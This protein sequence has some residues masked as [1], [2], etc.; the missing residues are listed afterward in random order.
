MSP[1]HS[2]VFA[3]SSTHADK[4]AVLA[5]TPDLQEPQIAAAR[6]QAW[7]QAG[8]ALLTLEAARTWLENYGLV[9]F[10]P[11]ALG[12]P[13]PSLVEATL[14]TEKAAVAPAEADT[15][16]TLV[17]RMVAEGSALPLNL[18]GTPGDLPDFVVSAAAFPFVFTLR[19]DK[20]W[21]RPPE[22]SG[23]VKVTPLALR[24][25]ELLAE[26]GAMTVAD[27]VSEAGREVT[28]SAISRS[29]NEL[30][31][32]LRVI[33]VLQQ[34][35]GETLWELTTA[36]FSKAVKAG[37]N[38]GQ[39]TA[40]SALIS[41]YL[42][43]VYIGS[44][45][46]IAT[47]LSPLTARSRVREVLHGLV[48]GRQLNEAVLEGKAVLYVPDTLPE[49][50]VAGE[51]EFTD[52]EAAAE[53]EED[54]DEGNEDNEDNEGHEENE[55]DVATEPGTEIAPGE[56]R[57]GRFQ[58]APESRSA[59]NGLR[60]K[61]VRREGG[62]RPPAR[63]GA[64]PPF[65]P[66][67]RPSFGGDR[68]GAS[69]AARPRSAG[70][71]ARSA[72]PGTRGGGYGARGAGA[73][74]TF[75]RGAGPSDR[76]PGGPPRSFGP[77]PPRGDRPGAGAGER[78]AFNRPWDEERASRPPRS[79]G[80]A[81]R[82]PRPP[83]RGGDD[84]RPPRREGSSFP[85]PARPPFR[86]GEDSR[87]PRRDAGAPGAD[88]PYARPRPSSGPREG[89][90]GRPP[91][92]RDEGSGG[93]DRPYRPKPYSPRA[94]GDSDRG[95]RS[96]S[97]DRRPAPRGD[98][99]FRPAG[100]GGGGGRPYTPKPFGKPA[101]D[102]PYRPRPDAGEGAGRD[103]PAGGRPPFKSAGSFDRPKRFDREGSGGGFRGGAGEGA[104]RGPARGPGG[105]PPFRANT[106]EGGSSAGRPPRP[107]GD[108]GR[109]RPQ[110][111]FGD[112]P[113][114]RP[115]GPPRGGA[116]PG[117]GFSRGPGAGPRKAGGPRPGGPG[118]GGGS[119]RPPRGPRPE[120]GA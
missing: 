8:D 117:G 115:G 59:K 96:A 95:E 31:S 69:G 13:A 114:F 100:E 38:A 120:D 116:R 27:I 33:P 109:P 9:L 76:G 11:R 79:E 64:R 58:A 101:G 16:R 17:A 56:E 19:G 112:R 63:A 49:M 86:G 18:L 26:K 15:A 35:E 41:L 23:A 105:R 118:P 97:G 39:P 75:D 66:G 22:T 84:S 43:Q 88:R 40:L 21:K 29:L 68:P 48:A 32:L 81:G 102:R 82:A 70:P 10:A 6:S 92:R 36:R 110:G 104:S 1:A 51:S 108:T 111:G 65:R 94:G 91:F 46:E 42:G 93:G 106:G 113:S 98:R 77:R 50:V 62:D 85:R 72:G 89:G 87:P 103:R 74:R 28:D 107:G 99:P 44:E 78:P 20:G 4:E 60:G 54:A 119:S 61:P 53:S 30:W 2:D 14:S 90:T 24:V 73:P 67:A 12:T 52:D 83:F 80:D 47:F 34:G 3:P 55:G 5:T 57:I 45:E 25:Y 71:G 37:A 7:H